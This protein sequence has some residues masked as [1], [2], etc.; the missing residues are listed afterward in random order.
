MIDLVKAGLFGANLIT[1]DSP[2]LVR[3]YNVC[4]QKMGKEPTRLKSFQI[5]GIG[6]SPEIAEEKEDI[7]YLS[8]TDANP[9]GIILTPD[10]RGQAIQFPFH[11]FDRHL[12]RVL[13]KTFGRQISCL[14]SITALYIELDKR[15]SLY[16]DPRDLLMIDSVIVKTKTIDG[17][18]TAAREQRELVSKFVSDDNW[19]DFVLRQ[20]I[21][22]SGKK[23]GDLRQKPVVIEDLP[24][25]GIRSF[26]TRVFGG[27]YVLRDDD[28]EETP[29]L[30][31]E[32][33]KTDCIGDDILGISEREEIIRLLVKRGLVEVYLE[34]SD[35]V[36]LDSI[37]DSIVAKLFFAKYPE[38]ELQFNDDLDWNGYLLEFKKQLPDEYYEI[39]RLKFRLQ[40]KESVTGNLLSAPSAN[41]KGILLRPRKKFE[42][43][44]PLLYDL[45]M[46]LL[47]DLNQIPPAYLYVFN[48]KK[49]FEQYSRWPKGKKKWAID[50]IL[51]NNVEQKQKA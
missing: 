43:E 49:F 51:K 42:K 2:E 20:Q 45:L 34:S 31:L 4:L 7:S 14:T 40:N 19:S 39:E 37:L 5:D 44:D 30:I 3:R 26:Y 35:V 33:E 6:W 23:F 32:D 13:F 50:R 10:Q 24:I 12:M 21:I 1:I 28:G 48:K 41:S 22:E 8:Y 9:C 27:V 17:I 36:W 16:R 46:Q 25:S 15:L 29:V 18:I 47:A 11:S 38:K